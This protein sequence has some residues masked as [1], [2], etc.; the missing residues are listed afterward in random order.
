MKRT[1][2]LIAGLLLFLRRVGRRRQM[3]AEVRS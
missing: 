3:L 2:M 1:L